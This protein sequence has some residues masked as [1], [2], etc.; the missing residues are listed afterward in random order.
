MH[1]L[2]GCWSFLMEPC[3]L[4]T[5]LCL[6]DSPSSDP[7]CSAAC[8]PGPSLLS[9][10]LSLIHLKV[11]CSS[12]STRHTI[13][14]LWHLADFPA[15]SGVGGWS[16]NRI[17]HNLDLRP[18]FLFRPLVSCSA[19]GSSFVPQSWSYHSQLL[20]HISCSPPIL[21]LPRLP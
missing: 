12:L 11:E 7:P 21:S 18:T 15:G 16:S 5:S 6:R 9:A 4:L 2:R 20:S 19:A 13:T 8:L 14:R 10:S 17:L 1:P 3:V